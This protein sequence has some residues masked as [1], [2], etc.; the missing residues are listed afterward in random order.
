MCFK[1]N[2]SEVTGLEGPFSSS[3]ASHPGASFP[4]VGK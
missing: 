3:Q 4:G 1:G 2:T